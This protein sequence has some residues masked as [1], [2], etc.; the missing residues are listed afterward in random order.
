MTIFYISDIGTFTHPLHY[1]YMQDMKHRSAQKC[2]CGKFLHIDRWTSNT[3]L[4]IKYSYT[5]V[6]VYHLTSI[7]KIYF[8]KSGKEYEFDK[9]TGFIRNCK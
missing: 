5:D 7:S 1:L 2:H 9:S 4:P 8:K 6:C 3:L